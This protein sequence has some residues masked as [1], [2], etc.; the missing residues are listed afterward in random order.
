[1]ICVWY[2]KDLD[3]D[4]FFLGV[5]FSRTEMFCPAHLGKTCSRTTS[6][7]L[8]CLTTART[9]P[10]DRWSPPP[11]SWTT[12]SQGSSRSAFTWSTSSCIR[13]WRFFSS[14]WPTRRFR[15]ERA[16]PSLAS[17]LRHTPFTS[18]PSPESSVEPISSQPS[19]SFCRFFLTWDIQVFVT[20]KQPV[21]ETAMTAQ[22]P[23]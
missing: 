8:R 19:S 17:F 7:A 9:S 20:N 3:Q 11:S 21:R 18:K 6:G 15:R 16:S 10:T 22:P 5:P 12:W 23:S 13:S 2:L 14:L 4:N 1:M